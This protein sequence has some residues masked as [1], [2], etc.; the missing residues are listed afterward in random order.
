MT[1]WGVVGVITGLLGFLS[2]SYTMFFKPTERNNIQL[3]ILNE[4]IKHMNA[5]DLKRDKRLDEHK[6]EIIRHRDCLSD[7]DKR[8]QANEKDISEI[9]KTT[10]KKVY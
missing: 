10:Y 5:N 4:N 8:I 7:H 2:I 1:E 6:T 3:N 9:K